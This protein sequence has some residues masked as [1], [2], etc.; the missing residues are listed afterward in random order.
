MHRY[1]IALV[2]ALGM[3]A[4]NIRITAANG[5]SC[6]FV[7]NPGPAVSILLNCSDGI[8]M[9]LAN[10]LIPKSSGPIFIAA[11]TDIGIV[12]QVT[13]PGS[14]AYQYTTAIRSNGVIT[15]WT[16]PVSGVMTWP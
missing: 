12:F 16:A 7:K 14:V 10:P 11:G 3:R 2:L 15:G 8:V 9:P 5:S 4:Q 1:A 13:L 6:Q